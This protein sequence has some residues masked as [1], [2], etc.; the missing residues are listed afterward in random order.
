MPHYLRLRQTYLSK[1]AILISRFKNRDQPSVIK[2]RQR[3]SGQSHDLLGTLG[4]A[5]RPRPGVHLQ[6]CLTRFGAPSFELFYSCSTSSGVRSPRPSSSPPTGRELRPGRR[7][8]GRTKMS[9]LK[10]ASALRLFK[11]SEICPNKILSTFRTTTLGIC[12][13]QRDYLGY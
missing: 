6:P 11:V 10:T 9:D 7:T 5:L 12:L 8:E 13:Q 3:D 2:M 1:A 4:R